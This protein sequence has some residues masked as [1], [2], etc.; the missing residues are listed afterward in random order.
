MLSVAEIVYVIP[1]WGGTVNSFVVSKKK[2]KKE[3]KTCDLFHC[4]I[5][6]K[7]RGLE[8]WGEGEGSGLSLA[9]LSMG[10]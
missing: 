8:F 5:T 10:T 6:M 9:M 2:K 7:A 3:L 4:E 1:Y